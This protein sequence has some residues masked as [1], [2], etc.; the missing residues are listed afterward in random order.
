VSQIVVYFLALAL[1][2][3]V[4]WIQNPINKRIKAALSYLRGET[5]RK[6]KLTANNLTLLLPFSIQICQ[7]NGSS[8]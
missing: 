1:P 2:C 3:E 7:E 5:L 8:T 6:R 4:G